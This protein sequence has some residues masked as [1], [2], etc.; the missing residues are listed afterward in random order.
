[1]QG[2]ATDPFTGLAVI[3]I[4]FEI[5]KLSGRAGDLANGGASGKDAPKA[6]A[7]QVAFAVGRN[8]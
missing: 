1:M 8:A 2:F 3:A 4:Q 6:F 7:S 5:G